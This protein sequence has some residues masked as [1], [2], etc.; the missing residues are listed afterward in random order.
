MDRTERFYKIDQLLNS[1]QSASMNQLIEE[2]EVSRATVKR[3]LEYMRERFNAPIVYDRGLEGYR[4][5]LSLPGAE[6]YSLPGLWFNDQE[7]FALLSMHH[8]LTNLGNSLLTP[9]IE[10]LLSRLD[11]LLGSQ[12]GTAAEINQRI[13]ILHVAYRNEKPAHFELVASAT[14]KRKRLQISYRARSSDETTEREISP[15]RLV[16]YRD[17]WYLDG[18]CHMRNGL[19]SF[20][21]DCIENAVLLDKKA[22]PVSEKSLHDELATSYGIF[23]GR[24]DKEAVLKFNQKQARWVSGERWHSKQVGEFDESG[25]YILKI[26]Y[27]NDNELIMDILK[28]GPDVEVISPNALRKRVVARLEAMADIYK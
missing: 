10:P 4:F 15:Q 28:Y 14:L 24:A 26:P 23:S 8:L 22:K 7:I 19:R 6:R 27:N 17:N 1:S 21:I 20:S 3:D 13:R 9:H 18:W 11:K 16:H 25:N 5:D 2:L 12:T